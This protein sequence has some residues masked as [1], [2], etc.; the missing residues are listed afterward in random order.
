[1]FPRSSLIDIG[2]KAIFCPKSE[3]SSAAGYTDGLFVGTDSLTS[4]LMSFDAVSIIL[5]FSTQYFDRSTLFMDHLN[6]GKVEK[7]TVSNGR[8]FQMFVTRSEKKL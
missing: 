4:F 1:M 5:N 3:M 8:P 7:S 2:M 6:A